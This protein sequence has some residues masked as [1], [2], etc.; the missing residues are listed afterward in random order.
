MMFVP[1]GVNS[2]MITPFTREGKVNE[3]VA[4][5]YVEF[6][7]NNGINGLFPVSS[8]GEFIHLSQEEAERLTEVVIEQAAGRVPVFPG[9]SAASTDI[10]V[11]RAKTA[12]KL[13]CQAVVV[14]PP[15]YS[16]V[17]QGLV[18]KHYQKIAAAI[19]IG[20][21]VYN[22]PQVTTPVSIDT[23]RE[24]IKIRNIVAL[25]DSSGDMKQ[26]L[27]CIDFAEE[28]GR[29][30][31]AVMTGWDD[32]LYP[33]L[34]VGAKGC[35]SGVSGIL[36]E[37]IVAIYQQFQA[38][39]KNDALKLQRSLL[40]VLRT[41]GSLQF[42]AGYKLALESRGFDTGPLRQ[43]VDEVDKYRYL[44]IRKTLE[45][46]MAELLGRRMFAGNRNISI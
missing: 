38:G 14:M 6:M 31:F 24:L 20:V 37:I 41:M 9:V 33:A 30:D 27:H 40:P 13:G 25:K 45:S 12:E 34:C 39:N 18:L 46:Q 11:T 42:P 17:S 44:T 1:S 7:I 43:P 4:R 23:F 5:D 29:T 21:I 10:A 16:P 15:Y 22:I 2:A 3:Q 19:N 32:L 35:V 28:A 26:I 8:I 36:P